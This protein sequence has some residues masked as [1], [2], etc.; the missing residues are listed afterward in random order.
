MDIL[1]IN[2]TEAKALLGLE[3][4]EDIICEFQTWDTGLV[5]LRRGAEGSVMIT[6]EEYAAV[7]SEKDADVKDPTGGGNSSSGAVLCGYCEK[8]SLEEC[9]RMG[10]LS[11]VMCLAQYGVPEEISLQMQ[12][13]AREKLESGGNEIC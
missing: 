13:A 10:N 7:P 11:A 3:K 6:A 12:Q 1:S 2:L 9:A 5:F 4:L 8:K